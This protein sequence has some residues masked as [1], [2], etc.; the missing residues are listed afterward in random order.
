M[1][2]DSTYLLEGGWNV[3]CDLCGK[4][5]KN[6]DAVK[7]WDNFYNCRH[8]KEVRNPQDYL[9]GVRDNPSVP[10][11]RPT[12][13]LSFVTSTFILLQ[14]NGGGLLQEPDALGN[15]YYILH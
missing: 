4:K 1:M 3:T 7:S 11:T 12:P 15:Y 6:T 14:E 10:F 13:P 5:I 8:H 9:R 2:G